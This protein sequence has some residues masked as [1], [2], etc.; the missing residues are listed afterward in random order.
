MGTEFEC[1]RMHSILNVY[2]CIYGNYIQIIELGSHNTIGVV[3][4][5]DHKFGHLATD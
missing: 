3:H 5:A 1:V 2:V 4:L